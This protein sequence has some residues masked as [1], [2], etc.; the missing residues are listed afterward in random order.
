M[1]ILASLA[2]STLLAAPAMAA[3]VAWADWT[4]NDSDSVSGTITSGSDVIGVTVEA[5]AP[6]HF[7]DLGGG[8]NYWAS[9]SSIY[10]G[11]GVLDSPPT[12]SDIIALGANSTVTIN[13]SQAVQNLY[14]ALVSWNING[15]VFSE[16]VSVLSIGCGYW[17]CGSAS[18]D[19]SG[20]VVN[21]S[22]EAHGTLQ[23]LGTLSSFS[24]T[25]GDEYW[26]GFTIGIA[27]AAPPPPPPPPSPI[28][29]PASALLLAGALGGLGLMR[30]RKG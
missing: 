15:I 23:V 20:K 10:T 16:P 18:V 26:H 7:V 21:L 5:T 19:A 1:K 24:F 11:G 28:P 12:A 30:R 13:F 8:V 3:P 27:G 29:L 6:F 22:G 2:L 17:G 4:S 9:N 25:H 14:I